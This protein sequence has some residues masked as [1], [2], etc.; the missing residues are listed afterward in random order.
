MT[1]PKQVRQSFIVCGV[2]V[3][4]WA[5]RWLMTGRVGFTFHEL[6]I[7]IR[8]GRL[9][10]QD[11]VFGVPWRQ[12]IEETVLSRAA[13]VAP[14]RRQP[15]RWRMVYTE[16]AMAAGRVVDCV[17]YGFLPATTQL[18]WVKGTW[19]ERTFTGEAKA[20][21][22]EDIFHLW[23]VTDD[24]SLAWV[25][26]N[27]AELLA[28]ACGENDNRAIDVQELPSRQAIE[29]IGSADDR[30]VE[31]IRLY[32]SPDSRE[33][34]AAIASMD[35]MSTAEELPRA[36]STLITA[37]DDPDPCIRRCAEHLI[38]RLSPQVVRNE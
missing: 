7:D 3:S 26:V 11:Y 25:Y 14:D 2:L 35:M 22:A 4:L 13:T 38:K 9:W 33:R 30:V 34:F 12:H 8:S 27:A 17:Y 18:R 1:I 19:E 5:I 32:Q 24:A 10:R 28:F 31:A 6:R 20:R 36:E 23:Q 37:R 16:P 29:A 15:P 21:M